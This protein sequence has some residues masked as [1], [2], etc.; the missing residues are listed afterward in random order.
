MPNWCYNVLEVSPLNNDHKSL[1]ELKG[2]KFEN[3]GSIDNEHSDLTFSAQVPV[4]KNTPDQYDWVINNW[5]TK[6]EANEVHLGENDGNLTYSFETAWAPP[7]PWLEKV[8]SY[9]SN[10]TF[11][12]NFEEPGVGMY[13]GVRAENGQIVE[14]WDNDQP[15]NEEDEITPEEAYDL[16]EDG[17][18]IMIKGWDDPKLYDSVSIGDFEGKSKEEVIST[19]GKYDSL[20]FWG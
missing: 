14:E 9:Y 4:P 19:L 17:E 15:G 3:R 2:F 10:L 12:L 13:G 5:G 7:I 6:W 16:L 8:S 18:D 20:Q 11:V 1:V